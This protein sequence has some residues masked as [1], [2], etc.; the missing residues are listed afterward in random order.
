MAVTLTTEW[1][2]VGYYKHTFPTSQY[3]NYVEFI[4]DAK[5]GSPNVAAGTI[6]IY[7]RLRSVVN[8]TGWAGAGYKYTC[9]YAQHTSSSDIWEG[10]D[11]WYFGTE[12]ILETITPTNI[13][14]DKE[15]YKSVTITA[16]VY[17][18]YSA[19]GLN[20]TKT[21]TATVDLPKMTTYYFDI[22]GRCAGVD[23]TNTSGFG[24]FYVNING[25]RAASDVSDFSGY[26]I[27]TTT[28]EIGG[29][30]P[31]TGRTYSGIWSGNQSGTITG[32]TTTVLKFDNAVYTNT[33][34]H[35][36]AGFKNGEGN[37]GGSR[38]F[39]F[40]GNTSFT[41]AYTST[42]TYD[43]SKFTDI[44]NGYTW[45]AMGGSSFEGSWVGYPL[46]QQFSQPAKNTSMQFD[47]YP[48]PYTITYNL[49]GGTNNNA[50]PT[51]YNVLYGVT[52]GNP[53]KKAY[54]FTGWTIDGV[55]VTGINPGA[56]A[57]F[58]DST[59]LYAGLRTRTTGNKTVVA[60]WSPNQIVF[61][62]YAN[63]GDAEPFV[64]WTAK[65]NDSYPDNHYNY[66]NG[67][68]KQENPGYIAT[69]YYGTTP[70]GG[71]LVGEDEEFDSYEALCNK[72]GVD[73]NN[74]YNTV[75]LYA[76]WV[77]EE[78]DVKIPVKVEGSWKSGVPYVKQS[79]E[80]KKG[81]KVYVKKEGVW[82]LSK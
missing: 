2:Q 3:G 35:Y 18:G 60:N 26:Y 69:G 17:N 73:I 43:S 65:A 70:D 38:Q 10:T 14:Y 64:T 33:I 44:P 51:S 49:N 57:Q 27:A 45:S 48:I 12:T 20:T 5:V 47:Y 25:V 11:T 24:T 19:L 59:A 40:L 30:A 23:K 80:W 53:T 71:I 41:A 9:T 8:A 4:V 66:S 78:T 21:I 39:I 77:P 34:N 76:Q 15:G 28:Y 6:P 36:A 75:N 72:Y 22:N 63:N 79:G 55:S 52:F 42:I 74:Q 7:T 32:N 37:S 54:T 16:T 56:T 50:N 68:Y 13:K 81:T 29:I 61:N 82:V 31:A 67:G 62:Y 58:A 46:G 1:Q